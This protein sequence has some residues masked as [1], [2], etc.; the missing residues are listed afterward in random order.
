MKKTAALASER[1]TITA[2]LRKDSRQLDSTADVF[3]ATAMN[4][5][6]R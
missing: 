3:Q 2:V 5:A 6:L 4:V 1:R